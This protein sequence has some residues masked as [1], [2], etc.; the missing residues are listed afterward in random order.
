MPLSFR[1]LLII[2]A[3][4]V[5]GANAAPVE[6]LFPTVQKPPT[7]PAASI[8]ALP[9]GKEILGPG[10]GEFAWIQGGQFTMGRADGEHEDE[11]PEHPVELSSFHIGRTPV[12]N[13]QFVRFLNEARV[14]PN[15]YLSHRITYCKPPIIC[16]GR[17]WKC[18]AG[19][20]NDAASCQSWMMADRYCRWL[21]IKTGRTSRLPT[22][23]EWE[24]T[25]R[26]K[27]GRTFPWGNNYLGAGRKIWRWS[28]WTPN[29]PNKIPVGSFPGGATPEGV[30]DLVGYMDEVCLDWYDAE[31]Y[32]KSPKKDP[33]GPARP[34]ANDLHK[35][36][37]VSRG[38]LEHDYDGFFHESEFF[39]IL[40]KSYLPRGWSRGALVHETRPPQNPNHTYGRLGFRVVVE[41]GEVKSIKD[42]TPSHVTPSPSPRRRLFRRFRR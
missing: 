29:R 25:C 26:G 21:S 28:T 17:S 27:E 16:V 9:R 22:E 11:R 31:Y 7:K 39:G 15:E 37:K 13:A 12:T 8:N 30:C 20:E 19:T 2:S 1:L 14:G 36:H 35:N 5:C 24:Y 10:L 4:F 38:G 42:D 41:L 23:A 18:V 3:F 34:L 6:K 32:A 40:P 33:R